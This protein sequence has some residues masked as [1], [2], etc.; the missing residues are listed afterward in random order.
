MT[1]QVNCNGGL[2]RCGCAVNWFPE[3]DVEE[4]RLGATRKVLV[5]WIELE[6][7]FAEFARR[8]E[9]PCDRSAVLR[10]KRIR[11]G[12]GV[13]VRVSFALHSGS[14]VPALLKGSCVVHR[15]PRSMCIRAVGSG[16]K[17]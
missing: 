3:S 15:P 7:S 11:L 1:F 5:Q 8:S 17:S 13:G 14:R 12:H 4:K 6:D 9:R 10:P 2:R 16:Q